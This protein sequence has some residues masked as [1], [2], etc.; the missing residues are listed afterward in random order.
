MAFPTSPVDGQ[1]YKN[2]YYNE[3]QSLWDDINKN[4]VIMVSSCSQSPPLSI[5]DP[6]YV[7]FVASIDSHNTMVNSIWTCPL[8]GQYQVN[9]ILATNAYEPNILRDRASY[10]VING[11]AE[12]IVKAGLNTTGI[13]AN[14]YIHGAAT[15]N[16]IVQLNKDDQVK[17]LLSSDYYYGNYS[18][19]MYLIN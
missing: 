13:A 12:L 14:A 6:F 11:N 18:W 4:K 16:G 5:T 8:S 19:S 15:I 7:P 3:L 10:L 17:V 9:V 2:Y 1:R